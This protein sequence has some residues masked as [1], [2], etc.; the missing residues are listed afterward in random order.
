MGVEATYTRTVY[1]QLGYY[2]NWQAGSPLKLGD[3]GT[4]EGR[5]FQRIGNIKQLG[6]GT[7]GIVSGTRGVSKRFLSSGSLGIDVDAGAGGAIGPGAKVNGTLTVEF[8]T[9]DSVFFNAIDYAESM[10]DDLK[11]LQDAVK[12]LGEKWDRNWAVVTRQIAATS[13]LSAVSKKAQAKIVFDATGKFAAI[14]DLDDA[15]VKF[16]AS[17][18]KDVAFDDVQRDCVPLMGLHRLKRRFFNIA[19]PSGLSPLVARFALRG[20]SQPQIDPTTTKRVAVDSLEE[21]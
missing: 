21:I 10:I 19:G 16:A 15:T 1:N 18:R 12:N 20:A 11:A 2:A 3:Y 4:V 5:W 13:Y 6:L 14:A 8:G 7:P 9:D 17:T